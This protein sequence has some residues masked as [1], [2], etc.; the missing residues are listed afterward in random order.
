MICVLIK[1]VIVKK[2]LSFTPRQYMIEGSG[3]KSKLKKIFKG[4]KVAWDKFLKPALNLAA[5]AIGLAI[6]AKTKNAKAGQATTKI[7]KSISGGKVL[8]LT[9]QNGSGLFL[10]VQ[11]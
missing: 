4:T 10:R 2:L 11:K 6:G 1:I 5:P 9:D 8:S 3:V 7:L